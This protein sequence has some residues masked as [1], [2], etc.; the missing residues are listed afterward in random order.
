MIDSF[1]FLFTGIIGIVTLALMLRFYKSNPFCNLF[2]I[3]VLS[4]VSIRFFIHG[5]YNLGLQTVLKPDRGL[6]S[7]LFL[8]IVPSSYLYYKNLVFQI[9]TFNYKDLKH[10]IFII[11]L[12]VINSIDG[13]RD[14]FIF[15]FGSYTNFFLISIFLVFYLTL[16]FRLLS[17]NIWFQKILLLNNSHFKL[18]KNWTFY[19]FTIHVLSSFAVLASLYIEIKSGETPSGKSMAVF[20]LFFWIFLFFKILIS[21]EILF[22][23]PILNK[24][25]LRFNDTI[26]ENNETLKPITDNWV[27]E[28]KCAKSNQDQKLE[29]KITKN[30]SSYIQEVDKLS[31]EEH[32]FRNQ[33]TSQNNIAEKL[34]V[35]TSHIVYLFK[36]HSK[37]SFSEYRM[38][39]RIKD[40]IELINE[41]FLNNETFESLAFTTGF[42]SYNPF[43]IAFKKITTF[44]PQDYIKVNKI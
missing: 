40:A 15:Y 26:S 25:L 27:L 35:P 19:F 38:Q 24:T 4:I 12:F 7:I 1:L 18:I 20:L 28:T 29:E 6:L 41:G 3:L 33:K 43:F 14:S 37:A 11:F 21:P 16:I 31:L 34:G 13:L 44:S 23:L 2:L 22:G 5:S 42:S 10:L 36:Y 8:I 30:I 39:S 9:N 32:I 17:K